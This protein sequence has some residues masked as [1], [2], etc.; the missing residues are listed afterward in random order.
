MP[1]IKFSI[2]D[3]SD[4]GHGKSET[5]L[6]KSNVPLIDLQEAYFEACN[7]LGVRLDGDKKI[8]WEPPCSDYEDSVFPMEIYKHLKEQGVKMPEPEDTYDEDDKGVYF[9]PDQWVDIILSFIMWQNKKIKLTRMDDDVQTFHFYGIDK[10]NRHIGHI[11]Y[12]L[13]N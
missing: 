5:F 11:G 3:W 4:D 1:K 9:N 10:Q 13:F 6:V 2:G 12:G 8:K 7:K